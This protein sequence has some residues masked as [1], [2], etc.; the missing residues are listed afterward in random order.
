MIIFL[1]IFL[2]NFNFPQSWI[3]P[4]GEGFCN[5]FLE[6]IFLKIFDLIQDDHVIF[7]S[8]SNV[9]KAL[10][11]VKYNEVKVVILGQDPYHGL[12]Q[13]N[14]LAFSVPSGIEIPPSLKNIFLELNSDL[15]IPLPLD[16]DLTRWARQGVL[17]LNTVLTVEKGQPNSHINLGWGEF[18]DRVIVKLSEKGNVVFVLWGK[19]A[20]SKINL[21]NEN[22]NMILLAP[23]PSP[24]SAHRGFF[25]CK[26][27]SKINLF[28]NQAGLEIIDWHLD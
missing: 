8:L 15:N 10:E 11:L 5:R 6:K 3:D 23:H 16:G 27:F 22:R 13:A 18:T 14:G 12:G 2:S 9:F 26:H 28:L 4:L 7:P 24:L 20:Q 25:G 21:I 1:G 17:L 19:S